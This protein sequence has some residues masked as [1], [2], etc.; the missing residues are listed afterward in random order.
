MNSFAVVVALL[1][2]S[3]FAQSWNSNAGAWNTGYGTVYGSFGTA[4]ATQR[5]YD[6]MQLTMQRTMARNAM[7]KKFGLAAVEKAE[8]EAKAGKSLPAGM[9]V[10]APVPQSKH[11]GAFKPAKTSQYAKQ[12]G[13]SL[14]TTAEEKNAISQIAVATKQAFEAQPET[15]TWRNDVAGALTFFLLGNLT[16]A[17]DAEE[18]SNEA[19]QALFN[20][21]GLAID[22]TPELAKASAKEKQQLYET[23][24]GF[25]GVPLAIYTD[26]KERGDAK[27]LAQARELST[28]LLRLVFKQDVSKLEL[29][30]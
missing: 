16:V 19:S 20:A 26:A 3:S 25:T 4:M 2:S 11:S 17:A 7:I 27:Q 5:M 9:Q 30:K 29:T 22:A 10:T 18:P 21:I 24:I 23:L 13:D 6:S 12:L 15:Q 1:A 8:R 14:G 28:Q